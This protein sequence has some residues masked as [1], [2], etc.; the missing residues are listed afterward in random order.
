VRRGRCRG[1]YAFLNEAGLLQVE[2]SWEEEEEE[3]KEGTLR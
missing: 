3:E 2:G 1:T